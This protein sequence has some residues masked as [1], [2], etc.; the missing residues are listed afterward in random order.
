M[1]ILTMKTAIFFRANEK[2]GREND[3]TGQQIGEKMRDLAQ[4][5]T[6][7]LAQVTSGQ[8]TQI[9]WTVSHAATTV[10]V[11]RDA[12]LSPAERQLPHRHH[13]HYHRV[14]QTL[15]QLAAAMQTNT[16]P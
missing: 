1:I 5:N 7:C 8:F 10:V 9:A 6:R 3:G 15:N 14:C 16:R 13:H 11:R 2:G 12:E 4:S